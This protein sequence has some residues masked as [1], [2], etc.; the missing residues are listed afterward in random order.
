MSEESIKTPTI[1]VNNL[2]P[3]LIFI[4]DAKTGIKFERS[5][6]KQ[7]KVSFIL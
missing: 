6:L 3:K 4:L 7:D 5:C 2:A 1:S